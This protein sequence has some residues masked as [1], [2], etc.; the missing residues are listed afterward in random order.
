MTDINNIKKPV[1]VIQ[2]EL[3]NKLVN[4]IKESTLHPALIVPVV[5][6]L[7]TMMQNTLNE[8]REK[9][10]KEY[11][12]ALSKAEIPETDSDN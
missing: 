4:D 8:I 3:A 10:K 9:E 11:E 5:N 6:E 7:L 1:T 2:T 12:D